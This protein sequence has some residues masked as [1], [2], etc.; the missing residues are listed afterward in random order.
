[1]Y[2][3]EMPNGSAVLLDVRN[4][5]GK[6]LSLHT[7]VTGSFDGG[8]YKMVLVEAL[9]HDGKL[10]TFNSVICYATITNLDDGRAYK[11]KLQAI[12]KREYDENVYH[13]LIS[14]EDASEEN[15]RGAKRFGL[16]EKADI[17]VLGGTT[18]LKGYVHDIS[19]TGIS[20]LASETKIAIGDKIAVAFDHEITGAHL[21]VVSQ[22]IRSAEH[23]KGTL[24]GCQILKHDAKYT[25][26]ISYLMRQEC[27]AKR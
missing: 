18:V 25:L 14:G 15:R 1:M 11:Y 8:D 17:Q 9:K 23:D 24:F 21:K 16:S 3:N 5:E 22:V 20:V 19:A 27:K 4:R 26:L 6:E 7:T 10:L 13:C 2:I 12:V